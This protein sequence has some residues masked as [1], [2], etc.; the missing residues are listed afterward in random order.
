MN[1]FGM[2]CCERLNRS[3]PVE[4]LDFD[5]EDVLSFT[6]PIDQGLIDPFTQDLT[7]AGLAHNLALPWLPRPKG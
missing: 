2:V 1:V 7:P 5:D 4:G 6:V 3:S